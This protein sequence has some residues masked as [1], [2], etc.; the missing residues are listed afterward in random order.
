MNSI[1]ATEP[2]N[3]SEHHD[4]NGILH[5]SDDTSAPTSPVVVPITAN[6][7]LKSASGLS[8]RTSKFTKSW[9]D[10]DEEGSEDE[11]THQTTDPNQHSQQ[12]T[13]QQ[14]IEN[15]VRQ[16]DA[17]A[18]IVEEESIQDAEGFTKVQNKK[19]KKRATPK[20]WRFEPM[21][22]QVQY[23]EWYAFDLACYEYSFNV[24]VEEAQAARLA[25][26]NVM[27]KH[28]D[29]IQENMMKVWGKS[30]RLNIYNFPMSTIVC[31]NLY[32]EK[33]PEADQVGIP[34]MHILTGFHNK[35][36]SDHVEPACSIIYKQF[37]T[38]LRTMTGKAKI[39]GVKCS[40]VPN[41]T[42][43][44]PVYYIVLEFG[45]AYADPVKLV[46]NKKQIFVQKSH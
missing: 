45:T 16:V 7:E 4:T 40:V 38:L 42:R 12:N 21:F 20:G 23:P 43:D 39:F 46:K 6:S 24:S 36:V 13:N 14:D 18:T 19:A 3:V 44:P 1:I 41:T 10:M 28:V 34:I 2:S 29:R 8:V 33:N 32:I 17:S 30:T 27:F 35:H 11:Y 31:P 5:T 9:A 37:H 26:L 25:V 22:D 15:T